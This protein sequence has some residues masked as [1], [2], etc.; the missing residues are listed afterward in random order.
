MTND[1]ASYDAPVAIGTL[2][3]TA[4][5]VAYGGAYSDLTS[6]LDGKRLAQFGIQCQNTSG[7][8]IEM[9]SV[10]AELD[11]QPAG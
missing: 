8:R 5:G 10:S 7:T 4:D 9:G 1:G 11:F 2:E 6:T 3:R